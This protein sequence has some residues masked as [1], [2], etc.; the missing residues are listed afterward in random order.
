M[1]GGVFLPSGTFRVLPP[2][3]EKTLCEALRQKV[4]SFLCTEGVLAAELGE[5][6]LQWRHAGFSVH[7]RIR[8]KAADADGRQRLA[9]YLIRC[10]FALEK[11]RYDASSGMLIYPS[12]L[13]ST[14]KR[15]YQ[16]MPALKCL[17]LLIGTAYRL[18]PHPAIAFSRAK[19]GPRI[20]T[21]L[22]TACPQSGAMLPASTRS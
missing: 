19:A 15:N 4:L 17:R 8:S 9:R 14:L 22:S 3:P 11:M 7:N 16:L 1:R 12:K 10:P 6:M 2:L 13:H 18:R 21:R 20:T 5:R